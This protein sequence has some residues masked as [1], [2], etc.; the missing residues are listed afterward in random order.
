[1]CVLQTKVKNL[2][3]MF[4]KARDRLSRSGESADVKGICPYFDEINRFLGDRPLTSPHYKTSSIE[5]QSAEVDDNED[6]DLNASN[7][8]ENE[9]EA[10]STSEDTS[11]KEVVR[12]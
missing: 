3:Q 10:A 5:T 8:D 7:L 1:M 12:E 4:D 9:P 6:E 11:D 2:R